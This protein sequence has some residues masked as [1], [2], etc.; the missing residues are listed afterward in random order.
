MQVVRGNLHRLVYCSRIGLIAKTSIDLELPAILKIA[1]ARNSA[2]D[3]T[4]ALLV[5]NGWFV[6]ALEGP[7]QPVLETY[8]RITRDPRHEQLT[9]IEATPTRERHF[10]NWS[11]CGLQVSPVD[12][13]I[14]QVLSSGG[15][16][17]PTKLSAARALNLLVAVGKMQQKAAAV[18][19]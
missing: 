9:I 19:L 8:G 4:G 7:M 10:A 12:R 6:Q 5:C 2:V 16:F 17:D 1:Q 3:V 11:M 14:V 13:E 18:L 15:A